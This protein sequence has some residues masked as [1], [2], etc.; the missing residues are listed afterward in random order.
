VL[1]NFGIFA[2][3]CKFL[4]VFA[5]FCKFLQVFASF[6]KLYLAG[7]D[8]STELETNSDDSI[9]FENFDTVSNKCFG[10]GH[11]WLLFLL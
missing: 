4:Q 3:F 11:G 7:S 1:E 9:V 8:H 6:C 2:S 5:S 10:C